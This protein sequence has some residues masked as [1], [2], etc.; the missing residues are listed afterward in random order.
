MRSA[1][2]LHAWTTH[3]AVRLLFKLD[4][5]T[6]VTT[7]SEEEFKSLEE[8]TIQKS[9]RKLYGSNRTQLKFIGQFTH[10]ITY[11]NKS[12]SQEIFVVKGLKRNFLGLPAI[13]ELHIAAR[14]DTVNDPTV[15]ML[16]VHVH[17]ALLS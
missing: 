15:Y 9:T 3:V 4:T 13:M 16:L 11:N 14:L 2:H 6:D 12:S 17:V 8:V 5:S 7:I 10:T 1:A